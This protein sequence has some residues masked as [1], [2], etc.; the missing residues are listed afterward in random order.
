MDREFRKRW[1]IVLLSMAVAGHL[2]A[3][4][5]SG[6]KT[7]A[8]N[9]SA[10]QA[11]TETAKAEGQ[12]RATKEALYFPSPQ[13]DWESLDARV[14]SRRRECEMC[15]PRGSYAVYPLPIR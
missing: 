6:Q 10:Q 14:E 8:Q 11:S 5:T 15:V 13:G 1:S 7:L 4:S 2:A 12:A 3:Q 9:T